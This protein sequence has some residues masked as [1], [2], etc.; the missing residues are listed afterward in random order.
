MISNFSAKGD[1]MTDTDMW[2][3]HIYENEPNDIGNLYII[4]FYSYYFD[5]NRDFDN[6]ILLT[7]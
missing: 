4:D 5:S 6:I 2:K 7:S 1:V 3:K